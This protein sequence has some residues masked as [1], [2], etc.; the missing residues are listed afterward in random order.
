MPAFPSPHQRDVTAFRFLHSAERA[1][2]V[3]HSMG[4]L[5]ALIPGARVIQLPVAGHMLKTERPRAV[6]DALGAWF[7]RRWRR[8][9]PRRRLK[10][11]RIILHRR[12]SIASPSSIRR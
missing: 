5:A 3:G 8:G 2:R 11:F 10:N 9:R 12:V 7:S 6:L 1:A 4:A